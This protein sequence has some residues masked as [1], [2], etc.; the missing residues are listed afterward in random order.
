MSGFE[1]RGC[2][3]QGLGCDGV[4][5]EGSRFEGFRVLNAWFGILGI[6]V[7]ALVCRLS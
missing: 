1:G 6:R 3:K 2:R 5:F 7:G 4:G